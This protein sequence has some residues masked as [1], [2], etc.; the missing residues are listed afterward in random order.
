MNI[1]VAKTGPRPDF[2]ALDRVIG[3]AT[4]ALKARQKSDGH[5]VFDL[6]A[7]AT[8]PS[9]YIMLNHY[10]DEIEPEVEAE[11]ANYIRSI[12]EEHGGWALFYNGDF[13]MSA[14]VK[15]YYALKLSGDD[16]EAPHMRRARDAV[17]ARGGAERANVFTRYALALFGEV[18][19]RAVPVM[20]VEL[21]LVPAWFPV[22]IY[23]FSYWSR[24]VIVPL[25]VLAA[26]KPRAKSP[27]GVRVK[28]LFRSPPDEVKGWLHNP[29]GRWG[30]EVFLW[31]DKIL[32]VVEP[33]FSRD[34]R[35][36]AL[37]RAVEFMTP[38]LNGEDGLLASRSRSQGTRSSGSDQERTGGAR[39]SA[40]ECESDSGTGLS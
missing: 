14:T 38:R 28:E 27:R 30:G 24:T 40:G 19:W 17:L 16:P 8:I 18:P 4:G 25:L 29:T 37:K 31:I 23:R 33:R 21:M 36:R 1:D 39:G 32:R 35:A 13:D 22:T 20:P 11:L 9:E 3:E 15:A 12:Q 2:T 10:L 7:D 6:E 26:L 34:M 5:W